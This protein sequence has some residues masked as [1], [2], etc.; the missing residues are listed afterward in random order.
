MGSMFGSMN[1]MMSMSSMGSGMFGGM[2]PAMMSGM[3]GMGGFDSN[4]MGH[5]I[6]GS[7]MNDPLM[8]LAMGSVELGGS[9]LM[10]L[11]NLVKT[12]VGPDAN[13]NP[14]L[15]VLYSSDGGLPINAVKMIPYITIM[16][17]IA[18]DLK[19]RVPGVSGQA[20]N[21]Q[22]E[23]YIFQ[24]A[25]QWMQSRNMAGA[26]VENAGLFLMSNAF[27]NAASSTQSQP[28]ANSAAA[29]ARASASAR[30]ALAQFVA[31]QNNGNNT[32]ASSS[33][34]TGASTSTSTSTL[35][36]TQTDLLSRLMGGSNSQSSPSMS[37]LTFPSGMT[38][39]GSMTSGF[40]MP[41]SGGGTTATGNMNPANMMAMGG[42]E[43]FGF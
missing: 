1:P 16:Q 15:M 34:G 28:Q 32:A 2:S 37:G 4:I 31:D 41:S 38:F 19:I 24:R 40:T 43:M 30:A 18:K 23:N 9:D 3:G 27:N 12:I 25:L 17:G 29:S 6:L 39:P 36:A 13:L 22:I 35:S 14:G 8:S 26:F 33:A 42:M 7:A 20:T 10:I 21:E 11:N 5:M